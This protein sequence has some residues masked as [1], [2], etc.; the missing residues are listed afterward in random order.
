MLYSDTAAAAGGTAFFP[1]RGE[2]GDETP[3]SARLFPPAVPLSGMPLLP[4][5]PAGSIGSLQMLCSI[6]F[7]SW[8]LYYADRTCKSG[9]GGYS[10]FSWGI[11]LQDV[12][13]VD[14]A[15]SPPTL[16]ALSRPRP[17]SV[18]SIAYPLSAGS[19]CLL[20]HAL[21]HTCYPWHV[22]HHQHASH[23]RKNVAITA[24]LQLPVCRRLPA[25][26]NCY[27]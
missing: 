6:S 1:L 13:R 18:D 17:L 20:L 10:Y 8:L 3:L 16:H 9:G 2:R 22:P 5:V 21:S 27:Q 7:L 25:R 15:S 23:T 4:M 24:G 12:L 19:F 14:S 26:H 11:K